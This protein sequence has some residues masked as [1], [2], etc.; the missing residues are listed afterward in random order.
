ML[1]C[2]GFDDNGDYWRSVYEI[3]DFEAAMGR[4]WVQVQPLYQQIHAY[5]RRR[6]R[7]VYHAH[8]HEFPA[9]GHIPG[10]LTGNANYLIQ[11]WLK[12]DSIII[13]HIRNNTAKLFKIMII[14]VCL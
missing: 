11:T 4:L 5:V 7:E 8:A 9:T 10:H 13:N 12:T 2:R 3:E 14:N 1:C 6:L